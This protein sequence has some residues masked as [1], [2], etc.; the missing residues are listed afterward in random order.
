MFDNFNFEVASIFKKSEKEMENL[1]HPYVG[2]EHLL[3]ALLDNNDDLAKTLNKYNVTYNKF[4]HEL[5]EIVGVGSKKSDIK[6]YTPL[7]KR[8]IDNALEDAKED[9]KGIVTTTHLFLALLE[10]AEGIAIRILLSLDVN[11]DK[12]Y[13]ELRTKK[14]QEK[15]NLTI[16]EIGNNLNKSVNLEEKIV[17]RDSE[18]NI[19]I[20]TL[21]RKNKNNP[22]LIGKAGVGKTAIVE[23]L[24]RRIEKKNVTEELLDKKIIMLEMSSLVAG[25]KY[26]GE[27]EE[28]LNKIIEEVIGEENIILFIDEVHTLVNAG[29]AEG[30]IDAA[31]I[32]KPYL[33]R[34]QLKC[35]GATTTE[36]Y[37]KFIAKDK[38]LERR[39]QKI[40]IKEPNE[41][42]TE[43][44][45]KSIKEEYEK[46]HKIVI[47]NKNIK[48]IVS[49]S[50]KYIFNKNN[51]DKCI[52]VLDSVCAKVKLNN[53]YQNSTQVL[54]NELVKLKEEKEKYIINQDYVNALKLKTKED[55]LNKKIVKSKINNKLHIL[56]SDIL[57]VIEDKT[58]IP[59]LENKKQI[60]SKLKKDLFSNIIGQDIAI[61]KIVDN[62]KRHLNIS[63]NKPLS[64]LLAGPTGVGKTYTVKTIAKSLNINFIRLDMSEY[65]LETAVNKL[66][67]VSAGY[68]GYDDNYIF[69]QIMDNPYSLILLDEIEKASPKV[70]NLFLQILEEGYIT[71]SS[72]EKIIFNNAFIFM[73]SNA[74][75]NKTMGFTK[76]FV[77]NEFLSNELINRIDEIITYNPV[78][79][80]S[81]KKYLK[82]KV[83]N[84]DEDKILSVSNYQ[85]Y[86]F[87]ELERT[88][89]AYKT[90]KIG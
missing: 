7:L 22:L 8:V 23:E 41:E 19:L 58:N 9:N 27:F 76:T 39:F 2:S 40:I 61:N 81:A 26:R 83:K 78:D 43:F 77:D 63:S 25:T 71:A 79:K 59:I 87:R 34:G 56:K 67:G 75:V 66:I 35:I 12:L 88:I 17:G 16:Y 54:E 89:K 15:E 53:I 49:L 85:K 68:V 18:I 38:A 14:N 50:N 13:K 11:L 60:I 57:K 10:E 47:T 74:S 86:G 73:T 30:A 84:G 51:P 32:L 65:N 62:Y 70:I 29:G 21:L 28:R 64:L 6:L 90:S 69:K 52:D 55:N 42:N 46:H 45:L 82:E 36:E 44:I 24:A 80:F 5:I 37:N 20:E 48:D 33:A 3:L 72:G 4:K 31:N 1:K